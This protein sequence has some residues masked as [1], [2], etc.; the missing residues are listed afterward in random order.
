MA[1]SQAAFRRLTTLLLLTPW[2]V[3]A[4]AAGGPTPGESPRARGGA[5]SGPHVPPPAVAPASAPA[6]PTERAAARQAR[7]ANEPVI[8]D[9]LA[10][11]DRSDEDRTLDVQRQ[12]GRLL[13][14][15]G[16]RP[17][18]RVAELMVGAGYTAELLARV[19]GA[20]GK[21]YAQ[22]NRYVLE[23]FAQGPWSERLDKPVMSHVQRVDRELDD[24]LPAEARG[25]DL[26]L[27]VLFYHDTVWMGA[28][29]AAMNRAVFEALRPGGVYGI[30]DHSASPGDG[31]A[32]AKSLH[33]IE[34]AS[35]IREVQNAGFRLQSSASFLSN[36]DDTR[37]WDASPRAAGERRGTSDR[38]VLAFVKPQAGD[39]GS[40][41]TLP[42]SP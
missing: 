8:V 32:V 36:P 23:R 14:F 9:A 7:R 42:S 1:K 2:L 38:F 41:S 15:Y 28:D 5:A 13:K 26:V 35:V 39:S 19:V 10:A 21:V 31:L 3:A 24:P 16:V 30:V 37:D 33:R 4:C 17:G 12:P 29:R 20:K 18:L 22:N 11:D 27:C 40:S 6:T 34:E 25:L